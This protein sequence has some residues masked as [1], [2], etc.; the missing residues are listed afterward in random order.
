MHYTGV[1][2][3]RPAVEMAGIAVAALASTLI[4]GGL[5]EEQFACTHEGRRDANAEDERS[6]ARRFRQASGAGVA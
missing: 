2:G 1:G 4:R 3:R 6:N 5:G